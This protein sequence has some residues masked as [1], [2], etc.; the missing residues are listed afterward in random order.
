L[1]WRGFK[2]NGSHQGKKQMA[3]SLVLDPLSMAAALDNDKM[4]GRCR[5]N[6]QIEVMEVAGHNIGHRRFMVALGYGV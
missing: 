1:I 6:N 2:E 3:R 4:E 5:H